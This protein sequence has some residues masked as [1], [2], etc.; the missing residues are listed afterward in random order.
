MDEGLLRE[1]MSSAVDGEP[2]LRFDPDHVADDAVRLRKRR[3]ATL[4][5]GA[6]TM[7]VIG[8]VAVVPVWTGAEAGQPVVPAASSSG[9][10]ADTGTSRPD[11]QRVE[12]LARHAV[13]KVVEL[14]PGA[15]DVR[16]SE[17]DFVDKNEE[18]PAHLSITVAFTNSQGSAEVELDVF[19]D[20]VPGG[21]NLGEGDSFQLRTGKHDDGVG[22]DGGDVS[23]SRKLSPNPSVRQLT[24]ER[25][26]G[27]VIFVAAG[28]PENASD[29]KRLREG[30]V[31]PRWQLARLA[32]DPKFRLE[33]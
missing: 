29:E 2:P 15:R 32:T 25:A 1:R 27:S 8:A 22:S 31:M 12:Q 28:I 20:G 9:S 7:A 10:A 24:R 11:E 4:G 17:A 23:K 14:A 6:A 16:A 18:L 33:G 26:D 13:D 3:R 30:P 5:S 21:V 19:P